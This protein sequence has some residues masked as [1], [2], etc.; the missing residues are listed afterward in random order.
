MT[1]IPSLDCRCVLRLSIVR[2]YS[3]I[4]KHGRSF[5]AR[6]RRQERKRTAHAARSRR[7]TNSPTCQ[8]TSCK[9]ALESES[10]MSDRRFPQPLMSRWSLASNHSNPRYACVPLCSSPPTTTRASCLSAIRTPDPREARPLPLHQSCGRATPRGTRE[11][12]VEHALVIR[13]RGAASGTVSRLFVR[14]SRRESHSPP[15]NSRWQ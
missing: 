13:R 10:S 9:R 6:G 3:Q 2:L 8:S 15:L 14:Y 5:H 11:S 1:V 4:F 7:E 12:L